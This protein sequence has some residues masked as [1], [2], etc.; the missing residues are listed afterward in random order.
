MRLIRIALKSFSKKNISNISI[1]LSA[2][3]LILLP[4]LTFNVSMSAAKE[5]NASK[6]DVFGAFSDIFY[7]PKIEVDSLDEISEETKEFLNGFN[8]SQKGSLSTVYSQRV[9][10]SRSIVAG[11]ADENGIELGSIKLI[12]GLFPKQ[13]GEAAVTQSIA[14][15]LGFEIGDEIEIEIDKRKYTVTGIV[16]DYGRLWVR[17]NE[18]NAKDISPINVFLTKEDAESLL[19]KTKTLTTQI[20]LIKNTDNFINQ[21]ESPYHFV[22]INTGNTVKFSVPFSFSVISIILS[23][24]VISLV[25]ILSRT[26]IEK[27]AAAYYR[28][29]LSGKSIYI[30]ITFERIFAVITGIVSGLILNIFISHLVLIGLSNYTGQIFSFEFDFKRLIPFTAVFF[31][32]FFA[33]ILFFTALDIAHSITAVKSQKPSKIKRIKSRKKFS[34][35]AF[36]LKQNFGS[37][38]VLSVLVVFSFTLMSYGVFYG[39]YFK[40]D[41]A[42]APPGTLPRDY[43]FQ[44]VARPVSAAPWQD[45]DDPIMFFTDTLEKI[46]ATESFVTDLKSDPMVKHVNAYRENDKYFTVFKTPQ[47]DD[48][49]DG[50]DFQLDG[51]YGSDHGSFNDFEVIA[52]KF[53]FSHDDILVES[54]IIGYPEDV[55][56]GLSNSICEG[57]INLDKIRSGEEII[58]RVPA[59]I[60]ENSE[61]GWVAH[62]PVLHTSEGAINFESLKVGDE[63][64]LTS[65]WTDEHING[66][67]S[68]SNLDKFERK[69]ATV[70]IGAIIRSTDGILYHS[71]EKPLDVLTTNDAFDILGIPGNYSTVSIY[72]N[73]DFSDNVL[74]NHFSEISSEVPSMEFQNWISDTK[75]YKIYNI[76]IAVYVTLLLSILTVTTFVIIASGLYNTTRFSIRTYA[77]LR[78]NGLQFNQIVKLLF[79]Q[80]TAVTLIGIIIGIPVSVLTIMLFG[81]NQSFNAFKEFM[82]FFPLENYFLISLSIA[83]IG[84]IAAIPS[85]VYLQKNKLTFIKNLD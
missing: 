12:S 66:A 9:S 48:Y 19:H 4:S 39:N 36:S 42:E 82:Y 71:T 29:G 34:L 28:L 22:N 32:L 5:I 24:A 3:L 38:I 68:L 84:I 73:P 15:I 56:L 46:G 41:A 49:I 77:L 40:S 67:V 14:E 85:I 7:A 50:S 47:I 44:F 80:S 45:R 17:G 33:L 31:V 13:N 43:D 8:I 61:E 16:Q 52:E 57:E 55:L 74:I 1:L 37:Y 78:I 2:I 51:I 21:A 70:K 58:L 83:A 59:Y 64:S 63:I 81:I 26:R 65:L 72:T 30:I 62:K 60:L 10:E 20:L 6:A 35:S 23:A 53:D 11:Y 75:T 54:Q 69:N 27:R 18:Q 76:L 79:I 25:L